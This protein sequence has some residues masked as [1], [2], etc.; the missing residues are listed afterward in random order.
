VVRKNGVKIP[1]LLAAGVF[2]LQAAAIQPNSSPDDDDLF[3]PNVT[4]VAPQTPKDKAKGT[5]TGVPGWGGLFVTFSGP[6][7]SATFT[8]M[9]PG[10]KGC[11]KPIDAV[12]NDSTVLVQIGNY[13]IPVGSVVA[14]MVV[15]K[16]NP[17]VVLDP[18]PLVGEP[19]KTYWVNKKLTSNRG[20]GNVPG[21]PAPEPGTVI[22]L[23]CGVVVLALIRRMPT[24]RRML[25]HQ[26]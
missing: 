25:R 7:T 1:V 14:L 2:S 13:N 15:A 11:P 4:F 22:M 18:K 26:S 20:E 6:I 23:A 24:W 3:D 9:A 10:G 16:D 19:T 5:K 8:I 21:A 12:V 17:T